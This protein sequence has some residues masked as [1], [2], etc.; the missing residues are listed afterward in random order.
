MHV[1]IAAL[2]WL[3]LEFTRFKK[4][5]WTVAIIAASLIGYNELQNGLRR[6]IGIHLMATS[7]GH[8]SERLRR[9]ETQE[10][11]KILEM[12]SANIDQSRNPEQV[13]LDTRS[14]V[15]SDMKVVIKTSK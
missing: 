7:I 1:V 4:A 10:V 13:F 6:Q 9:G 8:L 12:M 5:R 2:I 15:L 14:V 3:A 11:Q